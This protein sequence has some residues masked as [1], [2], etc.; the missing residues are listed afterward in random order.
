M[1]TMSKR[2][3]YRYGEPVLRQKCDPVERITPV[4]RQLVFD[5][6]ET[7]YAAPGVG[8]A[9]NQVGV[10]L[11]ICVI[12]V[13]PDNRPRPLVLINPRIVDRQEEVEEEEGCLSLPGMMSKIKRARWVRVE[14][15][16]EKGF[17]IMIEGEGFLG[18][19]L[20]HEV[21]HLEGKLYIDY[22]Q[23]WRRKKLEQEIKARKK[24]GKW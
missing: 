9:A 15:I 8:L 6:L 10:P 1:K 7:M 14:A 3:I 12:D 20:Q 18:R 17:P 21:D 22:L 19:A 5:L 11:R 24:E 23:P 16:N 4:I 2:A 13:R